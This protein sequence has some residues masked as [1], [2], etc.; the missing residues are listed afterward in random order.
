MLRRFLAALDAFKLI[1][2]IYPAAYE[3]RIFEEDPFLTLPTH[4]VVPDDYEGFVQT[5]TTR[6]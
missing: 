2:D 6:H 3:L 1:W 4:Y 5:N